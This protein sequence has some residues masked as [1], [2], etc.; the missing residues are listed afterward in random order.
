MTNKNKKIYDAFE[1]AYKE[2][3][4]SGSKVN[5]F[6]LMGEK[7]SITFLRDV[8]KVDEEELDFDIYD[9]SIDCPEVENPGEEIW[10]IELCIT[11][12]KADSIEDA[13]FT[14]NFETKAE[15]IEVLNADLN[16]EEGQLLTT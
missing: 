10:S 16:F 2:T 12:D 9:D 11:F 4:P 6:I 15:Q 8:A 5:V 14:L 3:L 1:L 7:E 13:Y